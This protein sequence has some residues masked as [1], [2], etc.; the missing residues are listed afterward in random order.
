MEDN[1]M[2]VVSGETDAVMQVVQMNENVHTV[3]EQPLENITIIHI[4]ELEI[5]TQSEEQQKEHQPVPVSAVPQSLPVLPV[6]VADQPLLTNQQEIQEA[7]IL[8]EHVQPAPKVLNVADL[9]EPQQQQLQEMQPSDPHPT[10]H[11]NRSKGQQQCIRPGCNNRAIDSWE[12]LD[13]YCSQKCVIVHCRAIFA[14]FQKDNLSQDDP[15]AQ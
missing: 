5:V 6:P 3:Q 13:E 4:Q 14:K 7:M 11:S 12:W 2:N 1:K 15:S 9:L 10:Q 8:E